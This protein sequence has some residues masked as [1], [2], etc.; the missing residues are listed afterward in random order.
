MPPK[1]KPKQ[2]LR[3][4]TY[5]DTQNLSRS[6]QVSEP[7]TPIVIEVDHS[8]KRMTSNSSRTDSSVLVSDGAPPPD[9]PDFIPQTALQVTRLTAVALIVNDKPERLEMPPNQDSEKTLK[10]ERL[11]LAEILKNVLPKLRQ[12]QIAV[13]KL[14]TML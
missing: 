4:I 9:S 2:K 3:E 1:C 5:K 6:E 7:R 14:P 13:K 12:K 8:R 10:Q 11:T